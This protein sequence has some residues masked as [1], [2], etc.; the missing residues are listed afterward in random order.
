VAE[1]TGPLWYRLALIATNGT[2]TVVGPVL[3][4]GYAGHVKRLTLELASNPARGEARLAIK[5]PRS[6]EA[7]VRIYDVRGHLVRELLHGMVRSDESAILH[8]DGRDGDGAPVASG[9][10][11]VLLNAAG[12]TCAQKIAFVK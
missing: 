6:G 2:R 8:W 7:I 12:S 9:V 5:V 11:T 3:A 4:Q 1:A 10:Y